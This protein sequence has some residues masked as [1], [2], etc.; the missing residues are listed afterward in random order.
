[1]WMATTSAVSVR[2]HPDCM[3]LQEIGTASLSPALECVWFCLAGQTGII[4]AH[5]TLWICFGDAGICEHSLFALLV[6]TDSVG[7]EIRGS[8]APVSYHGR[9]GSANWHWKFVRSIAIA[10]CQE[11]GGVG[12]W[13][14]QNHYL[15]FPCRGK[16]GYQQ[17]PLMD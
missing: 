13:R 15:Q 9:A 4:S 14:R 6:V 16:P 2:L 7:N 1:M 3:E 8:L 5:L 12:K 11:N 17:C 10:L